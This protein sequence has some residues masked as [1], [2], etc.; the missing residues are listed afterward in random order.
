[1]IRNRE[2]DTSIEP[3]FKTA[4][5]IENIAIS[6]VIRYIRR[7]SKSRTQIDGDD[8]RIAQI[9]LVEGKGTFS[10][11]GTAASRRNALTDFWAW[12]MNID[13]RNARILTKSINQTG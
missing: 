13:A 9:Q 2:P 4:R 10:L 3:A 6:E 1:L 8:V 7:Q 5:E 11:T 12:G